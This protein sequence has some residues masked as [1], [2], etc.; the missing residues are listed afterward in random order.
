MYH[1]MNLV[2]EYFLLY[3]DMLM[4]YGL[5]PQLGRRAK[6]ST[7]IR[8]SRK[9]P[10]STPG[11]VLPHGTIPEPGNSGKHSTSEPAPQSPL[12][13]QA[14][15]VDG[16]NLMV[17]NAKETDVPQAGSPSKPVQGDSLS[18]RESREGKAHIKT[19]R[20][21]R[22]QIQKKGRMSKDEGGTGADPLNLVNN[23]KRAT[24]RKTRASTSRVESV[25]KS[26]EYVHSDADIDPC[27]VAPAGG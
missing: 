2:S 16:N 17:E 7:G 22:N 8:G 5:E 20:A 11:R 19:A 10:P 18:G 24:R 21:S 26:D 25:I 9:L 14:G 12:V 15:D 13:V 3:C 27:S 6:R 4:R 1:Q 23:P